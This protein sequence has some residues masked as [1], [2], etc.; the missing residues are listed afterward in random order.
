[1]KLTLLAF[2]AARRDSLSFGQRSGAFG[3]LFFTRVITHVCAPVFFLLAGTG[4]YLSAARGKPVAEVS[5]FFWSR[6]LWL[7]LLEVTV[8]RFAWDF[9]F[10]SAPVVQTIWALGWSMI[11]MALI[12]RLP[13]VWIGGLGVG[14]IVFHNL[15]DWLSPAS[16]GN[17]AGLWNFLHVP[18]FVSIAPQIGVIVGYP[19]IPWV[20]VM[21]AGYALGAMLEKPDRRKRVF[22]LGAGVT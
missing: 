20:G 9:N 16:L 17:A 19:L 2:W 5:R 12:V 8:L 13:T 11:A 7:I 6:G 18:G 22:L 14:T 10:N 4:A 21:A 1:M 3:A 15:L